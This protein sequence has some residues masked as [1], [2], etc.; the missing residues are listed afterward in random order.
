MT[1][2]AR[3]CV[4]GSINLDLVARLERLPGPGETVLATGYEEIPG[5]KGSNQAIGL[6]RAGVSVSMIG[7]VGEDAAGTVMLDALRHE[8]IDVTGVRRRPVPTGRALIG[9]DDAAENSII[10][11]PGANASL[12]PDDLE[13][14]SGS[15]SQA[16]G[17]LVQL[18]IPLDTVARALELAGPDTWTVLNP[19]PGRSLPA[20]I[21]R[22]CRV[23]VPNEHEV[24]LLGGVSALFEAG[25]SWVIVTEGARGARLLGRDGSERRIEPFVVQPI[26]TTAAGDAFCAVVTARL[27]SGDDIERAARAAA[28]AGALAT[29]TPGAGPSLPTWSAVRSLLDA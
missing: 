24:Q 29:L 22:R 17:L 9:V 21:L 18:E 13:D 27:A 11:V 23:V 8:G 15:I 28:A 12:T 7:A 4:V 3:V 14:V 26:D 25:V 20:E 16:D 6:A 1:S 2:A 19:A 5:G 10:V